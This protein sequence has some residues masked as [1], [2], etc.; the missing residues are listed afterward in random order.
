[1]QKERSVLNDFINI[2]TTMDNHFLRFGMCRSNLSSICP[3]GKMLIGD[4]DQDKLRI[5]PIAALQN[6]VS[7][8]WRTKE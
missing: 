7:P 3:R 2:M 5:A 4:F 6:N 1:M 8:H